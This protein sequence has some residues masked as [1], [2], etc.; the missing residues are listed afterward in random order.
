MDNKKKGPAKQNVARRR[1][2]EGSARTAADY[3]KPFS[4]PAGAEDD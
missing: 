3:E 2:S 1:G 4:P